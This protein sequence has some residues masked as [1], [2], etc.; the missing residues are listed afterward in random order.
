MP[1]ASGQLL[2]DSKGYLERVRSIRKGTARSRDGPTACFLKSNGIA[3]RRFRMESA[4]AG[5][6]ELDTLINR[7]KENPG[8]QARTADVSTEYA[9]GVISETGGVIWYC[10]KCDT[11]GSPNR[12]CP[13]FDE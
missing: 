11:I 5:Q 12:P 3:Q 8:A 2:S 7:L 1:M 4:I 9:R 10:R 6:Q 13:C